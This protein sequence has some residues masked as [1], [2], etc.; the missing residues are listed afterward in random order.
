MTER[1]VVRFS[2]IYCSLFFHANLCIVFR[3][4]KRVHNYL[5][6]NGFWLTNQASLSVSWS[7]R[8]PWCVD[9]NY[10]FTH[11]GWL[12]QLLQRCLS[13]KHHV[14]LQLSQHRTWH[15]H[16][17]NYI[18][19]PSANK[20]GYWNWQ[21]L[22]RK[23][24]VNCTTWVI[25]NIHA[26]LPNG[27]LWILFCYDLIVLWSSGT[28]KGAWALKTGTISNSIPLEIFVV[29]GNMKPSID[30]SVYLSLSILSLCL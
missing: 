2:T 24:S 25:F 21:S 11:L 26:Y 20:H 8:G 5:E 16:K 30:P 4:Q 29:P 14:R 15:N 13:L 3:N 1:A 10:D 19:L 23:L 6:K 12:E 28:Q 7:K 22:I 18:Q 9:P 27:T 17:Y